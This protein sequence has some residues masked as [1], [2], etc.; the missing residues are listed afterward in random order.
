VLYIHKMAKKVIA[1]TTLNTYET[2]NRT[3]AKRIFNKEA[4]EVEHTYNYGL[5]CDSVDQWF[6]S[7]KITVYTA[8]GYIS[9]LLHF[10][11]TNDK[12]AN[13]EEVEAKYMEKFTIY[14]KLVNENTN[15]ISEV[16]KKKWLT[17]GQIEAGLAKLREKAAIWGGIYIQDLLVALLYLTI[18]PVR[19]DYAD[20]KMIRKDEAIPETGNYMDLERMVFV[21][22]EYKTSGKY[23]IGEVKFDG[24][25]AD[26]IRKWAEINKSGWFLTKANMAEPMNP[27]ALGQYITSVIKRVT[28][29]ATSVNTLRKIWANRGLDEET[30]EKIKADSVG[31]FHTIGVHMGSY[32]GQLGTE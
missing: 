14:Y 9:G 22:R 25:I 17:D 10:I 31:M 19:L 27:N 30:V 18:P 6:E 1:K 20:S 28:G 29:V 7:N 16:D 5:I 21:L 2:T 26:V 24:E 13:Y 4:L 3:I 32:V 15:G 23:G 11:R 8:K 12:L